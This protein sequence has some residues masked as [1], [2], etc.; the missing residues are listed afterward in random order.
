MALRFA[1]RSRD[2]D[3]EPHAAAPFALVRKLQIGRTCARVLRRAAR[4]VCRRDMND[5]VAMALRAGE[6]GR[7]AWWLTGALCAAVLSASVPALGQTSSD[8]L[9]R[10]HFE[11][12]V[13]YLQE[14]DYD[15]ALKAF[16]KAYELSKRP[17]ILLNVAT[18][19]E[20][21]GDLRSAIEALKRYLAAAPN[22]EEKQTVE[23]R[24]SNLEKRVESQ[25]A[26]G[27]AAPAMPSATAT[28]PGA[29]TTSPPAA[30]ERPAEKPNR[31]PAYIALSVGGVAAAGAILTGILAKSD[32]D[33]AK[34]SCSPHCTDDQLSA[35]RTMA[36]TSTILTGVAVVG[37]GIGAAL[38]L[39]SG[40]K[41]EATPAAAGV[42]RLYI[43][44]GS[45]GAAAE[46]TWR[47]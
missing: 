33:D 28:S 36:L 1:S 45:R 21:R 46:A 35:G 38:L 24:I 6:P 31:I 15:N 40:S 42:P 12:G 44:V 27:G 17:E 22:S 23:N 16:E 2:R 10:K 39:T 7:C 19:H 11:S 14:S 20:R 47:F 18:V 37:V 30:A 43:G 8:E 25:P 26:D 29:T 9:A 41:S 34:D 32:Y 13:A 3:F 4:Q 5:A